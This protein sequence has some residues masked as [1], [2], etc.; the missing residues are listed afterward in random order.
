VVQ[1]REAGRGEPLR[2]LRAQALG[3]ELVSEEFVVLM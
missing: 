2:H 1:L 3:L